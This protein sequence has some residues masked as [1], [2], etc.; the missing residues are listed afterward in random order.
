MLILNNSYRT[1]SLVE[2][3]GKGESICHFSPKSSHLSW[4]ATAVFDCHADICK[5]Q[6]DSWVSKSLNNCWIFRSLWRQLHIESGLQEHLA[7][8]GE[9]ES[10]EVETGD[11]VEE[12]IS[13]V[14]KMHVRTPNF[15]GTG[16]GAGDCWSFALL[17]FLFFNKKFPSRL[18]LKSVVIYCTVGTLLNQVSHRMISDLALKAFAICIPFDLIAYL[19]N[20]SSLIRMGVLRFRA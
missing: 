12:G 8:L 19:R 14:H 18:F 7:P 13:G 3:T 1:E 15:S 6:A 9:D 17:F 16:K 5:E 11:P 2:A 4:C 10:V 20:N